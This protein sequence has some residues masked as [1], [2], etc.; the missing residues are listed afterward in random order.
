MGNCLVTKLKGVVDNDNLPYFGCLTYLANSALAANQ[1]NQTIR[2]SQSAEINVIGGKYQGQTTAIIPANTT[3]KFSADNLT[4]DD[5][6]KPIIKIIVP[7]YHLSGWGLDASPEV[8]PIDYT[9]IFKYTDSP[10]V[11]AYAWMGHRK[12]KLNDDVISKWDG[13]FIFDY[14]TEEIDVTSLGLSRRVVVVNLANSNFYGSLDN[15]GFSDA[16]IQYVGDGKMVIDLVTFV[17]NHRSCGRTTGSKTL[18]FL[19]K[20]KEVYAN[21]VDIKASVPEIAS[22]ILAWTANSIT[23]DGNPIE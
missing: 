7:K 18:P 8:E 19:F 11:G 12:V 17:N 4:A 13:S 2:F 21:G 1:S 15:L 6:T 14:N 5:P 3:I 23:L 9:E 22:P 10:Y 20:W 16:N